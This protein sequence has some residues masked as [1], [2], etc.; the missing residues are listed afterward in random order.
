MNTLETIVVALYGILSLTVFALG[1]Y[2][3]IKK[4]SPYKGTVYLSWM[5]IFVWGDALT[6]GL[7]WFLASSVTLLM[8]DWLLFLLIVSIFWVVRSA[9]E[10]IYWL[11]QQF[12]KDNKYYEKIIGYGLLKSDAIMFVYQTYWQCLTVI[13][14]ILTIYITYLWLS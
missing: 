8:S 9:G 7:F 3:S 14:I 2:Q 6:I 13:S 1:L 12:V 10:A 4:R 11:N 5:G